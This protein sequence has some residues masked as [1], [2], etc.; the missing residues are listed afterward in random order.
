MIETVN[1]KCF[2]V[3]VQKC[4]DN[5]GKFHATFATCVGCENEVIKSQ[6][7]EL[8]LLLSDIEKI[9]KKSSDKINLWIDGHQSLL[10]SLNEVIK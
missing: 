2:P 6:F 5:Q 8:L 4:P 7:R 1:E 10:M 3:Y 9:D